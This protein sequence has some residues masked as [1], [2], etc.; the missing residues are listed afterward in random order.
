MRVSPTFSISFLAVALVLGSG[1]LVSARGRQESPGSLS[2]SGVVL[3]PGTR[4]PR[5]GVMVELAGPD[6]TAAER[7][8]G[9]KQQTMRTD[10]AGRFRFDDLLPG[11]YVA[12]AL[13]PFQEGQIRNDVFLAGRSESQIEL[14]EGVI[15]G[16][17]Q[18]WMPLLSAL[19]G[20]V[21]GPDLGPLE[22]A[23]VSPHQIAWDEG[24]RLMNAPDSYSAMT[25]EAG[26]YTI[27]VA[28]GEYYL[29]A[30]PRLHP[31]LQPLNSY[32]PS[33]AGPEDAVPVRVR[34]GAS[35]NGLDITLRDRP[36]LRIRFELVL[37]DFLPGATEPLPYDVDGEPILELVLSLC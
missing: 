11:V 22:G 31:E 23:S 12:T 10:T 24:R 4:E 34:G 28:P 2:V 1:L 30:V 8:R 27:Y 32:Y 5:A 19:S 9:E 13:Q 25:D 33:V 37:P 16:D 20:R 6:R 14:S 18:V 26:A 21:L 15:P 35:L 36:R 3:T 29:H 7:N 17:V